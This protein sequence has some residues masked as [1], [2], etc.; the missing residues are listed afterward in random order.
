MHILIT[1]NAAW[2]ISNFRR[3]LV[4][5]LQADGHRI[6]ILAPHD[7]SV[8]ALRASGC[9]F[10][11]LAMDVKGLNPI[12]DF[13]LVRRFRRHFRS[14]RP[15][16]VLSYTV[17]N[18]LFGALAARPLGLP[19]IPNITGLGT[20]FLSGGV[21]RTIAEGL[22]RKAFRHPQKVFFQNSDDRDFFIRRNLIRTGQAELVPGSGIDLGHFAVAPFPSEREPPIFLMIARLLRDKGVAEFVDAAIRVKSLL[23]QARFQLLG[24]LAPEN[25]G[26]I[27]P[28]MVRGWHAEGTVEYLGQAPDV[29]PHIAA[30]S[31]VVLPSYREGAPR[32]LIEAAA[33]ARPIITTDV[34]G[35][36]SVIEDG[37][38][39]YLCA[40]RS[41][42]SLA[43]ACLKFLELR[44]GA[45][46]DM[47]R[48]GREK[49]EREFDQA[50]VIGAYRKV[51][52]GL[53]HRLSTD[54]IAEKTLGSSADVVA[55]VS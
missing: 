55:K 22:Y 18:N 8:P 1:V 38:T 17:K 50:I 36:R 49:M 45:R 16:V 33:M 7:D 39:G 9:R 14:E 51:L 35:C 2:N 31:C 23:P 10:I 25:R 40:A 19:F 15:D 21:L 32:T 47:G 30:A 6:T 4:E 3:S 48:Q 37:V 53:E 24:A 26:A 20:A 11:P 54:R 28:S 43:Q 46:A 52:A 13:R 44:A 41:A 12:A 42:E 34:P 29:R 5:A 27:D